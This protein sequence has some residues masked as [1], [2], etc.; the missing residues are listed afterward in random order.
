M[1]R[2]KAMTGGLAMLP[3]LLAPVLFLALLT[4]AAPDAA[5]QA[6]CRDKCVSEEQACLKRT[7]NKSQCGGKAGQC[8]AK[9][10]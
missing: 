10:K 8:L 2:F 1:L 7:G 3:T 4:A 6:Q 9:C 5:A